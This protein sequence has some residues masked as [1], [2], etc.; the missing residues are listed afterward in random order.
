MDGYLG[1]IKM[2]AGDFAPKGWMICSGQTLSISEYEA[3]YSILGISYGGDGRNSFKLPDLRG[4]VALGAGQSAGTTPHMLGTMGGS[5]E[6]TLN[7]NEMPQHMHNVAFNLETEQKVST[8]P[9]DKPIP[10]D[11]FIEAVGN[12]KSGKTTQEVN[13]YK[14]KTSSDTMVKLAPSTVGG[15]IEIGNTGGSN[16]H[17][18]LQ[19]F[20]VVNYIICTNGQY[21]IRD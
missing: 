6:V 1:E 9:A 18:N 19:P 13:L 4:R 20:T 5:E 11:R 21:P 14:E 8:S 12:Y 15:N 3:L 17:N 10:L 7:I 16:P 2:F